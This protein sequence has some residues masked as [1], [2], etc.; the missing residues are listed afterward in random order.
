M[1]AIIRHWNTDNKVEETR[2][3]NIV[4]VKSIGTTLEITY[5]NHKTC[6]LD[7]Y[8]IDL[9]ENQIDILNQ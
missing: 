2:V 1:K 8:Y 6:T 4:Q 9:P 7:R 3:N 5:K